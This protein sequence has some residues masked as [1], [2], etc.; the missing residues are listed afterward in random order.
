MKRILKNYPRLE[1][2]ADNMT[3]Q[4]WAML[5]SVT[6]LINPHK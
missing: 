2:I 4:I 6:I 1:S 5:K 3:V